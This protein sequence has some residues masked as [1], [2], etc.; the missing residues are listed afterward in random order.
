MWAVTMTVA[1]SVLAASLLTGEDLSF[2]TGSSASLSTC[3]H[4][5]TK[6]RNETEDPW[7]T[8]KVR[9]L[10]RSQ[11]S[12]FPDKRVRIWDFFLCHH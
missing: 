12:K 7:K 2:F 1:F 4:W 5:Y 10:P 9:A 11:P 8:T 3:D 6:G